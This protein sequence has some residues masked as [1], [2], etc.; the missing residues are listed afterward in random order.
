[1]SDF[2]MRF[3]G[4][5]R[6][7][8]A[9]GLARL[10]AAHV[11]VVGLGGVG[12]WTV[13]ALARSGIG[14]LTLVDLDEICVSN[15]NRQLHA[16][17]GN[18]GRAKADVLAERVRAVHPECRVTPVQEFFTHA[19]AE[20]ILAPQF[21][22]VV[23][24]IDAVSNKTRLIAMCRER[25]LVIVTTGG[26]GGRRD[27]TAIRVTDLAFT[28][29]DRL[30]LNVRVQLRRLHG[31]PRGDAAFGVPC[32][33]SPEAP[34]FPG[35]HGSVCARRPAN[36]RRGELQL[37]CDTGLGSATFVTGAFG[38]AAAAEVVKRLT[39]AA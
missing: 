26:A 31:F 10:R 28:E 37:N 7:Y 2:E 34:V 23:D 21:D 16:L 24:A 32:V 27:P 33:F 20:R 6:L 14:A 30:L 35:D 18:V 25:N 38:F 15:V 1:M 9:D 13:E 22:A 36:A 3:G 39:N 17:D 19:S 4:I 29:H 12:S 11:C 5:A 8:G